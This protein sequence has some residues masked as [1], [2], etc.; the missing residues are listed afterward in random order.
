[1]IDTIKKILFSTRLMAVLFIVF[2]TA[3]AFGTFIESWYSTETSKIWVYNTWWFE[4]IMV[5]FMINFIGNIKRYRLWK[6]EQWPVLLLHLSFV[7]IILG[8]FVTRYIGYEGV[9]PIREGSSADFMLTEKKY[10]TAFVDG[11]IDG[12]PRRRGFQ[13]EIMV[14]P[15]AISSSL[16]WKSDFNGQDFRIDFAGFIQGAEEGLIPSEVGDLYLKIVEAGGGNRHDHFLKSG[17]VTSIHNIL[18]ALNKP[19]AGAVNITLNDS[20]STLESPFAGSFMRMADQFQGEVVADS[21][22]PLMMRSLYNT[23]GMQFVFPEPLIRGSYGVVEAEEKTENQQDALVLNVTAG[24]ETKQV[25]LLGG[26]GFIND[27]KSVTVGGLDFALSYGSIRHQLPFAIQLNDFIAEKYPGTERGY[28]SFMSKVTVNDERSFDYDIYMNHVLDHGGYRFFQSSFDPDE[29]GTVLSVNHDWWGTW[30]TYVGYFLLYIGLMGIMFFGKTRFKDLAQM[31]EKVKAKKATLTALLVLFSFQQMT[32]QDTHDHD[33]D[34]DHEHETTAMVMPTQNQIDSVLQAT[35]VNKEHAKRFGELVVQD[36]RG[37]MKPVNTF[38]SELLRKLSKS[39]EFNGM[40]ANQVLLSMLQNPGLWYNVDFI[41]ITKKNDS[42]RKII[43]VPEGQKYVT[44]VDFFDGTNYRLSSYLEDAYATNT[45]NQFQKGFREF[46]L[47]LGLLNQ[48]LGGDILRIYPLPQDEN[49]KWVS[50][51]EFA[52]EGF[53]VQDSLY[54]NFIRNSL[55]FYMMSLRKA[56]ATGDYTEANNI[57]EALHKNQQN[58]GGEVLPSENKV[59]AEIL[60]NEVNIFEKL[61]VYYMLFGVVMF[62]LIIFQIFKDAKWLRWGITGMKAGIVILFLLQTAGLAIRWY[63]SGHA[64]WS[65]AYESVLYVSWST[66]ALGLAFG[67]KSDLTIAATAFVTAII[68]F[69]AHMNWLDPAIA[70]LQPVLDSYWLMIHVAV[71][72]GSYGPF[73]MGMILGI[74]VLFLMIFTTPGNK[75]KMAINIQ[76]LTIINELALTVGLVMLTIGNFLGGQWANES[77]GRYWGWD[78]KETWAL[79]SIMVYAF[80]IHMRLVPGLRGRWAF[81][82]ASIVAYASI[83]MTYFGVNFY[84][85]GLHSYASGDK[86]ITPTF[87]W[88]S[89][90][91]VIILGAVSYWAYQR[92][93]KKS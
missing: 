75:K 21:I 61:L 56:K 50:A 8:A 46:D 57:L 60:Y 80:V 90:I 66:M 76:E 92:N 82:F 4:V 48:A 51:P 55:P 63:I 53:V 37:R 74:V 69:G 29:K 10:V 41:Y 22:Q 47:K 38:A 28:S 14:T 30:I 2:A 93:Y 32:A 34:H 12:E 33:T 15:E 7:L 54:A 36:E 68:L 3:M 71:I 81:N 58:F 62:A 11:E 27:P 89:V 52:K 59:K 9:M 49:N 88:Y 43:E 6:W 83:M 5:F 84:L 64:P 13:D 20:V 86:V 70:N 85:T 77:W 40:D 23:A 67:R 35:L 26:K 87:V 18:F 78:P 19:T 16:P 25:K 39:D 73:T 79:I 72:V 1:M 31:L 45:P 24:G 44:A 91:F 42:I 65:D 17:E